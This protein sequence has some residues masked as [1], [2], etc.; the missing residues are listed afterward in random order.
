[1]YGA[2]TLP[3][4]STGTDL[5]TTAK[6]MMT[7]KDAEMDEGKP[8]GVLSG[9]LGA[10]AKSMSVLVQSNL[11]QN[12]I[13][14]SIKDAILGT[15]QEQKQDAIAAGDTDKPPKEK[16]PGILSRV[17]GGLKGAF[18]SLM[19]E[20]GGFMDTLL[21]LGLAVGGVA[22]L[23]YFGDD[24][25]PIL[26]DL[27]KS[28]KEGK[29]GGKIKEAYEYIKEIGIDA[30]EKVKTNTILFIDGVKTVAGLIA[31][32]F[33]M[34]NDYVMSFDTTGAEH[35]AGA[36]HGMIDEGDGL[37]DEKELAALRQDIITKISDSVYGFLKNIGFTIL[38]G[39]TIY[40]FGSAAL[41]FLVKRA[42]I[43]VGLTAVGG[44]V[45]V[46]ALSILVATGIYKLVDNV[47]TAY[48]D[49]VTD[50]LGRPQDFNFK[51]F[52]NRLILGKDYGNTFENV[53]NNAFDKMII[54]AAAGG[55]TG[56]F[57]FPVLGTGVG[58]LIGGLAG[59]AVGVLAG[60]LG[61]E[62]VN[63]LF[64]VVGP[65]ADDMFGFESPLIK[66]IRALYAGYELIILRPFE[67]LFGKLGVEGDSLFSS[68]IGKGKERIYSDDDTVIETKKGTFKNSEF[69]V[70][71]FDTDKLVNIKNQHT[72]MLA[73]MEKNIF[74]QYKDEVT[75]NNL[76][77]I[78]NT[79]NEELAIRNKLST[80]FP[81]LINEDT[82]KPKI[83]KQLRP[84][85][86]E[87]LEKLLQEGRNKLSS[88]LST[89]IVGNNNDSSTKVANETNILGNLS[90]DNRHF[91]ALMLG[92][93]QAKMQTD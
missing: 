36:Q 10:L 29:I 92:Y 15:P 91:T 22:L 14:L 7:V 84:E 27:L 61:E 21:K 52:R 35:P 18:S 44:L 19:P 55:L 43:S 90:Q 72:R 62:G 11:L 38:K 59:L 68:I 70:K 46:A 73:N 5:V 77:S 49:A 86:R 54:G 67:L 48:D 76:E 85:K 93:K 75:A 78:L 89:M 8:K 58:V 31:S 66:S 33:K 3:A 17:M 40:S 13:L 24:M 6:K 45:G 12:E 47:M 80:N 64:D 25:V 63:K 20:K 42:A 87:Q 4:I 9:S 2:E 83:E 88:E 32:A 53:I 56:T 16:G 37:L 23:K 71:S 41:R 26:A 39:L 30:F 1:M 65:I 28:I 60:V 34:V 79:A 74:G 82:N 51:E 69:G 81:F 57:V 50:E